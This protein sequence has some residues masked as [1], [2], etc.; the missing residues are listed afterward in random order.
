[1]I[2]I[3]VDHLHPTDKSMLKWRYPTKQDQCRVDL[4]QIISLKPVYVWDLSGRIPTL[5]LL[6]LKDIESKVEST[7]LTNA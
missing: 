3:L 7:E 5:K 1:M 6:N 4:R 2:T